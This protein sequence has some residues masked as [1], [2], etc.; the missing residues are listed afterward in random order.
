M[1]RPPVSHPKV[2]Q[3]YSL[4]MG[5][6]GSDCKKIR[7]EL[8]GKVEMVY[9]LTGVMVIQGSTLN[10]YILMMHFIICK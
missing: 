6:R 10:L 8:L 3:L 4:G 9:A 5:W 2:I 7:R 1:L